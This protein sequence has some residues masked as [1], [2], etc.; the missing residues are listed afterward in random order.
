[1]NTGTS[2]RGSSHTP[3]GTPTSPPSTKGS[4][5]ALSKPRRTVTAAM[6][7]PTSAPK[8]ASTAASFGSTVQA[9]NDIAT[10]PKA[11]PD[12]PCTKPATIAPSATIR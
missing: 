2:R 5:S 10:S 11:K 1:M 3:S 6:I 12:R 7:C 9:Q 4:R 8:V